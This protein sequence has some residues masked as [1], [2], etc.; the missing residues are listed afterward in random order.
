MST[1]GSG[2]KCSGTE[3][4]PSNAR[5]SQNEGRSYEG[6]N[7]FTSAEDL[8]QHE[9]YV[10]V[11]AEQMYL[12]DNEDV[13]F[14]NANGTEEEPSVELRTN[15]E[16]IIALESEHTIS[17]D[18]ENSRIELNALFPDVDAFRKSLRHFVIKNEFEYVI[19]KSDKKRFIANCKHEDCPWRIRAYRL[20]DDNK[21]FKVYA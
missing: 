4:L 17:Y 6:C 19:V 1:Y 16:P 13:I 10:E 7:F 20:R 2:T 11:D 12:S 18:T 21:T 5:G 9:Q 14:P 15:S 3:P 8:E